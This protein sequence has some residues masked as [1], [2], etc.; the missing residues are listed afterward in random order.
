M[1]KL[2]VGMAMVG[3]GLT[4]AAC[5]KSEPAANEAV[6]EET[7]PAAGEAMDANMSMEMNAVDANAVDANAADGNVTEQGST[8]H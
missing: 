7:A 1:R 8:D 3:L 2:T 4:L 5:N 6:V